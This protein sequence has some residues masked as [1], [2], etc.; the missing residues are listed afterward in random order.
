[1]KRKYEIKILNLALIIFLITTIGFSFTAC[2]KTAPQY[3]TSKVERGDIVESITASGT[4]DSSEIKNYSLQV[5]GIVLN[6]LK[7]GET[8]KSGQVLIAVDNR[9]NEILVSQAEKNLAVAENSLKIAKIN[10]Q[11]ALNANHVAIQLSESNTNLAEQSV[12]NAYKAL[13]DA[14]IL[15]DASLN[16]AYEAIE[17]ANN[18]L[19]GVKSTP[20]STPALI[21]QAEGNVSSAEDAYEQAEESAR[22]QTDAANSAYEQALANQSISYWNNINST[23]AAQTQIKLTGSNIKQ[24]EI[25]LELSNINLELTKLELDKNLISAPFDGIVL[26]SAF[27]DGEFASPGMTAVSVISSQ[28]MIK[29]DINE[30]DIAKIIPGQKVEITL[31][32]YPDESFEGEIAETSPISKNLAGIVSFEIKIKPDNSAQSYLKYGL[33]ANVTIIISRIE[34]VL[35]IPLLSVYEEDGKKYVDVLIENN[36][37]KKVEITTGNYNYDYIE[38]KSGLS[39]GDEIIISK[40]EESDSGNI[41][42]Q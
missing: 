32:A 22:S 38:V 17:N 9:R 18:Y 16:S 14:N 10:Y 39:E 34:N 35:Y 8:F 37:S 5:S 19:N 13:E 24:A 11:Q 41:F 3:E 15:A 26:S 20:V 12:Q 2:R 33:S 6:A 23:Q 31:D 7:K 1:M 36:E 27:S 30:T 42:G 28:F 40:I 4:V 25:Q 29:A 21:A